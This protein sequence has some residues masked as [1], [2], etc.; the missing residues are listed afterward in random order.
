MEKHF[1]THLQRTE[2]MS[3]YFEHS[4]TDNRVDKIADISAKKQYNSVT[5]YEEKRNCVEALGAGGRRFESC[6]L[7]V[8]KAFRV[9]TSRGFFVLGKSPYCSVS[10]LI[11]NPN[12]VAF[13][14]QL[15]LRRTDQ[16]GDHVQT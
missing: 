8:E 12:R 6:H 3:R 9:N 13:F 11:N 7:D 5:P 1:L 16:I 2:H 15:F 4:G 10:N 14:G